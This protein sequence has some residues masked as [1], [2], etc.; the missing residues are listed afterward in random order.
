MEVSLGHEDHFCMKV[1]LKYRICNAEGLDHMH[2][3]V[4]RCAAS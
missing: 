3:H 1:L 2:R 4:E